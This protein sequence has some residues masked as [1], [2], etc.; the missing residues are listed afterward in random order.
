MA[1]VSDVL[2]PC[3]NLII[4]LFFQFFGGEQN[5][6]VHLFHDCRGSIVD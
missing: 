5:E 6:E 3:R 1:C 2:H 4:I